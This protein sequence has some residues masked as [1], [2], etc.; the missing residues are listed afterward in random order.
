MGYK[1]STDNLFMALLHKDSASRMTEQMTRYKA[2]GFPGTPFSVCTLL[3]RRNT[4]A[5]H[6]FEAL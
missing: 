4:P 2:A 6:N 3:V 1:S 5:I